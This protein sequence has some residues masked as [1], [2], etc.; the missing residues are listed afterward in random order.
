M[1]MGHAMMELN[2]AMGTALNSGAVVDPLSL[3]QKPYKLTVI[4]GIVEENRGGII[5]SL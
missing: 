4:V 2:Q 5:E 3:S 1:Q